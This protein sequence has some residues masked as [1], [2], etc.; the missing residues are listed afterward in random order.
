MRLGVSFIK[1][2]KTMAIEPIIAQIAGLRQRRHARR[3][4]NLHELALDEAQLPD[5][6]RQSPLA[7]FHLWLPVQLIG[8]HISSGI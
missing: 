4:S 2:E 3:S 8:N 7:M 6:V 5:C 1:G